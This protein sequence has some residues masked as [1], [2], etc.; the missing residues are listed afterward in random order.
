MTAAIDGNNVVNT[1]CQGIGILQTEIHRLAA[2]RAHGL[3]CEYLLPVLLQRR[4]VLAYLIL[5]VVS[6]H[7]VL[8][9][10]DAA[11]APAAS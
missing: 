5:A 11:M 9:K 4:A 2:E 3:G 8:Q 1:G 7:G 10:S 6:T